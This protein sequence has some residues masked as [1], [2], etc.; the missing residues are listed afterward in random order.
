MCLIH[1]KYL[2]VQMYCLTAQ[3]ENKEDMVGSSHVLPLATETI[4]TVTIAM[5]R[6]KIL[7]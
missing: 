5:G 6:K 4:F 2:S 7:C 3:L 1:D